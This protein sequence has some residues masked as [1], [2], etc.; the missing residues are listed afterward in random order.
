[1][2]IEVCHKCRET[3]SDQTDVTGKFFLKHFRHG[4]FTAFD[5]DSAD[6]RAHA[7]MAGVP[8]GVVNAY[9]RKDEQGKFLKV[10]KA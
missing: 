4:K 1:L 8:Y 9:K 10:R 3:N 7:V 6:G 5:A 2:R